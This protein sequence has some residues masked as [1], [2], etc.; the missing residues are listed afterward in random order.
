MTTT[1][2]HIP[3]VPARPGERPDFSYL[4]L[5]EPGALPRPALDVGAQQTLPLSQGLVRVLDARHQAVGQWKPSVATSTLT[6]QA[7][8]L[9]P[10]DMLFPS[11]RT[12]GLHIARA[13]RPFEL[14]CQCLSNTADLCKGRQMPVFYH[15]RARNIFSVSGNVTTRYPQAV[16]WA[17]AARIKGV[18]DI[19]AAWVGEGSTAEADFHYALT[20]AAVYHAPVLLNVVNN[21]WAIST[22]QGFAGGER[23][24]FAARGPGFGIA[25]VRV[26]GNDFLAV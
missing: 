22:F 26:D 4:N 16:G 8:A 5:S 25:G 9:E 21:Q 12:Q 1:S 17:M 2:L 18:S 14:M 7:M 23:S 11:Y 15:S 6:A 13:G 10:A 20:F 19:A 3:R 24:S